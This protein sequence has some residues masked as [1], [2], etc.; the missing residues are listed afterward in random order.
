V[1]LLKIQILIHTHLTNTVQSI[2]DIRCIQ[3]YA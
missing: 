3:N 2:F 1:I